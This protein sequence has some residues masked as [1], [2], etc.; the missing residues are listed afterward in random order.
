MVKYSK[1]WFAAIGKRIYDERKRRDMS[2]ETLMEELEHRGVSIGRNRLSA[3]ENGVRESFSGKHGLD[4][5]IALCSI[6]ECDL[7]YLVG[8]YD[9]HTKSISDICKVTGLSEES[10]NALRLLNNRGNRCGERGAYI[11]GKQVEELSLL[12]DIITSN[13]FHD[14]FNALSKYLVYGMDDTKPP[15]PDM[16]EK[17]YETIYKWLKD[18]GRVSVRKKEVCELHLQTAADI[19]KNVFREVLNSSKTG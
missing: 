2:Q 14:L 16:S 12:D 5:L 11:D 7:G 3:M 17:E 9:E 1:R 19:F 8:E 6:F 13:Q 18:H 4:I 15:F 10:V